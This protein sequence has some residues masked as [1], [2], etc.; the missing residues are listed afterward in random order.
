M[1]MVKHNDYQLGSSFIHSVMVQKSVKKAK[2]I[3]CVVDQRLPFGPPNHTPFHLSVSKSISHSLLVNFQQHR[4]KRRGS[5]DRRLDTDDNLGQ[6]THCTWG[7]EA[8]SSF[9]GEQTSEETRFQAA[10][11]KANPND[12]RQRWLWC[13]SFCS[14]RIVAGR[15]RLNLEMQ[16]KTKSKRQKANANAKTINQMREAR[17][18]A[19]TEKPKKQKPVA[20]V[21]NKRPCDPIHWISLWSNWFV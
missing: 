8:E 7:I 16:K 6:E 21:R 1:E 19:K 4:A 11:R 18:Y 10:D 12:L 2:R 15:E 13:S 9:W 3:R 14:N 20:G 17:H 5:E